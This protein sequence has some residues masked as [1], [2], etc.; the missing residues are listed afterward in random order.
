[1][2]VSRVIGLPNPEL[3][4]WSRESIGLTQDAAAKKLKVRLNNIQSWERGTANPTL[5]QLRRLANIYKRPLAVFYLPERPVD[6]QPLRDFRRPTSAGH[7]PEQSVELKLA[8]RL[9]SDR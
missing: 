1:M 4:I 7:S 6:F 9:A 5:T 3:L 8:I 2:G